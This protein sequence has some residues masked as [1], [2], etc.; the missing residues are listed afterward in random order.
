MCVWSF[1][2]VCVC[3]CVFGKY[4]L[5]RVYMQTLGV[6][7]VDSGLCSKNSLRAL[8]L[9]G[10]LLPRSYGL[11]LFQNGTH[12]TQSSSFPTLTLSLTAS[13]PCPT[14]TPGQQLGGLAGPNE[15]HVVFPGQDKLRVG[16]YG[17]KHGARFPSTWSNKVEAISTQLSQYRG[18][19]ERV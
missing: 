11:T 12:V 19:T 15:Y 6:A 18:N 17:W 7:I 10:A 9:F 1:W 4:M 8:P 13:S 16:G 14:L 2:V 5:M 3:V